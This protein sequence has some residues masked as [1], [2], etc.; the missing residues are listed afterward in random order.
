[1]AL[2]ISVYPSVGLSP[3]IS[4]AELEQDTSQVE[5]LL[6]HKQPLPSV[7][8][9]ISIPCLVKQPDRPELKGV[10]K[11]VMG[12][13]FTVYIPDLD[14]TI[15]VSKLFVYPDFSKS[16]GQIN[17]CSSKNRHETNAKV[18]DISDKCSSKINPPS[19]TRMSLT[20][21]LRDSAS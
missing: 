5:P 13:R 19:K 12:D 14:S 7:E 17:K 16:D 4:Q 2:K 3:V 21:S 18:S 11:E 15:T 9:S 1:M 20:G 8:S 10:I 6:Q